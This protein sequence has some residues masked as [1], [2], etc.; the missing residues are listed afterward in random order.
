MAA[1]GEIRNLGNIYSTRESR[2]SDINDAGDVVGYAQSAYQFTNYPDRA[3]FWPAGGS[4]LQNLS[5]FS[6]ANSSRANGINNAAA[7]VGWADGT[8]SPPAASSYE[9]AFIR[10]AG[11]AMSNLGVLS[12]DYSRAQ[13]IN[14]N[15]DVV[16]LN[17]YSPVSGSSMMDERGFLRRASDASIIT[18]PRP[19]GAIAYPALALNDS[20]DVVGSFYTSLATDQ[21]YLWRESTGEMTSL[22]TLGGANSRAY[23]INSDGDVVGDA[24]N[25]AGQYRGFIRRA[26]D[27][28]LKPLAEFDGN[29]RTDAF[30]INDSSV[31]VGSYYRPGVARAAMWT[32]DGRAVD[33]DAWLDFA[34]P[35]AGAQWTIFEARAI[36]SS[37][38]IA[39]TGT[40]NDGP[41]GLSDGTRAFLLD[42]SSV[43]EPTS[44]LLVPLAILVM[45]RARKSFPVPS[46]LEGE[47]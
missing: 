8:T 24:Q 6:G 9:R 21:A 16:G 13:A 41:G 5:T 33:L 47:G 11:A 14:N 12:G 36:N 39:G 25:S 34:N 46:P 29:T 31:V 42:A 4:V 18:L 43:P 44:A 15:G 19:A 27:G 40:Y 28:I 30:D 20:R 7:T 45:R 10:Q 17:A 22:G 1:P 3:I 2:A 38:M 37:G 35:A 32:A 23:A 26:A